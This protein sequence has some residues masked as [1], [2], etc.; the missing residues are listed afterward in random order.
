MATFRTT[1]ITADRRSAKRPSLSSLASLTS[2]S[3]TSLAS[4]DSD[5]PRPII[6]ITTVSTTSRSQPATVPPPFATSLGSDEILPR[7]R[8]GAPPVAP[9]TTPAER[10]AEQKEKRGVVHKLRRAVGIQP[11]ASPL[12]PALC[13]G[14]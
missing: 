3:I 5:G 14:W 9:A 1:S 8:Q 12:D 10:E 7:P 6:V 11:T 4:T 2:A 13:E